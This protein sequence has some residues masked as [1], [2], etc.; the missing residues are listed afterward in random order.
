MHKFASYLEELKKY[1][2]KRI[3]WCVRKSNDK[4]NSESEVNVGLKKIALI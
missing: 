2:H 4:Q 1:Q 3:E